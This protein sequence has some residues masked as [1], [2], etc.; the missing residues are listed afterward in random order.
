MCCS[1]TQ[2]GLRG[3]WF[4]PNGSVLPFPRDGDP[5]V[6]RAAQTVDLRR[7]SALSPSG[8]YRCNIAF[9]A[10]DPSAMQTFYVGVYSNGGIVGHYFVRKNCITHS[11]R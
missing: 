1:R 11:Y 7:I 2:G 9:D 10:D 8:I 6:G 3:D 4:F 5:F